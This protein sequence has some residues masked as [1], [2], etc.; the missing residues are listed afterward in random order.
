MLSEISMLGCRVVDAPMEAN[1]KLP[2]V[3]RS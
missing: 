2:P 3:R 1:V